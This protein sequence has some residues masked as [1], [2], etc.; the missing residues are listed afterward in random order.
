[1]DEHPKPNRFKFRSEFV[2]MGVGFYSTR[3]ESDPLPSLIGT[4]PVKLP[5]T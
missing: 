5:K 4:S 2:S 1:M 3:S